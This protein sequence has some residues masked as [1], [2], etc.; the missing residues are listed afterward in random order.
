VLDAATRTVLSRYRPEAAR[1]PTGRPIPT[2]VGCLAWSQSPSR[3]LV[4]S[5]RRDYEVSV[6]VVDP[7]DGALVRNLSLGLLAQA[8][9]TRGDGGVVAVAGY[10]DPVAA[11]VVLDARTLEIRQFLDLSTSWSLTDL[12]FSPDGRW[13]AV[14]SR[15]G[16]VLVDTRT[17]KVTRAP[18]PLTGD[19]LQVEWFPDN[20]TLAVAGRAQAVYLFDVRERQV[21]SVHVPTPG[22]AGRSDVRLVPSIS[23][24]L[25]VLGGDGGGRR[26]A[27]DPAAWTARACEVV[28]GRDL[29]R[30][31]W[32]RYLPDRPYRAT[33]SDLD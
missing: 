13:I 26:Y 14:T 6:T 19:V 3:L 17:W 2:E 20:R 18:A 27:L 10:A 16:L 12:A 1:V 22:D 21:S 33:C 24:E 7:R 8:M 29:T 5:D 4:C 15:D 9:A 11:L 28:V 25:V 32:A 30:E 31:E 23:D